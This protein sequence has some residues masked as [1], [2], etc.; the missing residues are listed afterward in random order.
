MRVL[1]TTHLDTRRLS[2]LFHRYAEGWPHERLTAG[3]RYSRGADFSGTCLYG[4]RTIYVNIRRRL[5][6]PYPMDTHIARAQSDETYWW[7]ETYTV[8]L[9]DA[10][11]VALF[12][13]L[14]EFFHWLIKCARRNPRR[15][16]AMCD[17]FATRAIVDDF[18]GVVVDSAGRLVRRQDWD[19]QNLLRFVA[20]AKLNRRPTEA[21]G[22]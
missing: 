10:Y 13:F 2:E 17:R 9:A 22:G 8:H 18:G 7:K 15:K 11:Q 14:H 3:V 1:N 5:A 20:A 21:L 12:V 4:K 16:E 6:F 19:F